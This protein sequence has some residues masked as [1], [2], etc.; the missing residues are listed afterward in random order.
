MRLVNGTTASEG[1]V[2]VFHGGEWG[3]V[4]DNNWDDND[5]HVVCYAL[6]YHCGLGRNDFPEGNSHLDVIL[7]AQIKGGGSVAQ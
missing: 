5:A 4:C 6:G 3:T 7:T 2:E 1:R